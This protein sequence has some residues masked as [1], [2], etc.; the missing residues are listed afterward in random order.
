VHVGD[1][2]CDFYEFWQACHDQGGH[3]LVRACQGRCI[4]DAGG[5]ADH[6]LAWARRQP[7][8]ARGV[9]DIP[10][11]GGRPARQA[12]VCLSY[13]AVAVQP[14]VHGGGGRAP[15]SVSVVR[16]WE[17]APPPGQEALEWVLVGSLPVGSVAEAWQR[18]AW[19]RCRWLAEDYHQCLKTGCA[20]GRRPLQTAAALQRLLGLLGVVAVW[21]LQ[22]RAQARQEPGRPARQ[23]V[24]AEVVRVTA[25]LSQRR[26]TTAAQLWRA[27]AQLGGYRGRHS[28]GPPGWKTLWRGWLHV[29]TVLIGVHIADDIRT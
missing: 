4:A 6:L 11:R 8:L 18:V 16:V 1:S 13:G 24:P 28:D 10:E 9:V 25:A 26:I 23:V 3:F 20:I 15:L 12:R 5:R 21:L 22:L 27:L 29:Q 14:P 7:A 19:Y 2:Y 17:P